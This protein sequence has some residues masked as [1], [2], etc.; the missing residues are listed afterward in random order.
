MQ[1]SEALFAEKEENKK[2]NEYMNQILKVCTTL[3]TFLGSFSNGFY[4]SVSVH[5]GGGGGG[6]ISACIAG[7]TP[8]CLAGFQAHTQGG[9][10]GDLAV[11]G[12]GGSRPTDKGEV[13]G[14]QVQAHSQGGS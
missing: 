5:S 3:F 9:S 10:L 12:G 8:A 1:A 7:G 2:L 13:D 14:D 6:A 11:L 4:R